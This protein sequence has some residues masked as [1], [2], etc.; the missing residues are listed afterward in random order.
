MMS[1]NQRGCVR[2]PGALIAFVCNEGPM[3]RPEPVLQEH[4]FNGIAG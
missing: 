1:P 2:G 3:E 4:L